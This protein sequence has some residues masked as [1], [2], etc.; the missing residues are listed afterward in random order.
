MII[1]QNNLNTSIHVDS[2]VVNF[3]CPFMV[4][5]LGL[6]GVTFI[7]RSA[8]DFASALDAIWPFFA[9]L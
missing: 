5:S 7:S 3:F 8:V 2:I 6:L 4:V 1:N 9:G